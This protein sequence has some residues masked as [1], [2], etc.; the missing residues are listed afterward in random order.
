[1]RTN[2]CAI[3]VCVLVT[4]LPSFPLKAQ[5]LA[6]AAQSQRLCESN[7]Q[8]A[9]V[10]E[11]LGK[12]SVQVRG[13]AEACSY[14]G[15]FDR[16]LPKGFG[17]I[18]CKPWSYV[19]N[20]ESE[21]ASDMIRAWPA[22]F[23]AL[24]WTSS[25]VRWVGEIAPTLEYS[26]QGVLFN[27]HGQPVFIGEMTGGGSTPITGRGRAFQPRPRLPGIDPSYAGLG[28]SFNVTYVGGEFQKIAGSRNHD[29]LVRGAITNTT[30]RFAE[31]KHAAYRL[32]FVQMTLVCDV[33]V[34]HGR[35]MYSQTGT[36]FVTDAQERAR[37]KL[38]VG[39]DYLVR[40]GELFP[41]CDVSQGAIRCVALDREW[42][43]GPEIDRTTGQYEESY[44]RG[45]FAAATGWGYAER[46][47]FVQGSCQRAA[48]F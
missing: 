35:K 40:N 18:T 7:E 36:P 9:L 6:Q 39:P 28:E 5:G 12:R 31:Q 4:A 2:R 27:K 14:I 46:Q 16:G 17:Q 41:F 33:Q 3:L 21:A 45:N 44:S 30:R 32:G 1:M 48:G 24:L 8:A 25:Q 22:G 43:Y 42:G 15:Q 20:V 13:V 47:S 37:I 10:A 38:E 23:G 11:C 34:L 19:G 29:A 26:G